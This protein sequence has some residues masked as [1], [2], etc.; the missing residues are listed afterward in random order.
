MAISFG[1]EL[2]S[3]LLKVLSASLRTIALCISLVFMSSEAN[4]I[5][6]ASAVYMKQKSGSLS[7]ETWSSEMIIYSVVSNVFAGMRISIFIISIHYTI[8]IHKSTPGNESIGSKLMYS[9]YEYN[10]HYW[11]AMITKSVYNYCNRINNG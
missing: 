7:M 10:P 8:I 2:F 9:K 11:T 6:T 5:A 1:S 4:E 3:N